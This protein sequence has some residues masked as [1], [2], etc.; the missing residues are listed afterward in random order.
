MLRPVLQQL[1]AMTILAVGHAHNQLH[2]G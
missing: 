1:F 2:S